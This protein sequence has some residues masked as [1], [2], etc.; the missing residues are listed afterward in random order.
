MKTIE[1]VIKELPPDLQRQ[2]IDFAEFLKQRRAKRKQTRWNRSEM[3]RVVPQESPLRATRR[4]RFLEMPAASA[5]TRRCP[6]HSLKP[7][8]GATP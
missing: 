7:A 4:E 5:E 2:V 6:L 3:P 1:D 8:A